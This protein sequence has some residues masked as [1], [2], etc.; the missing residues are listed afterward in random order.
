MPNDVERSRVLERL[1]LAEGSNLPREEE[2]LRRNFHLLQ[3]MDRLSLA[4]CSTEVPFPRVD[5]VVP[6]PGA[7]AVSVN[8]A[9]T[10]DFSIALDPWPFDEESVSFEIPYRSVPAKAYADVELFRSVYAAAPANVMLMTAHARQA[11]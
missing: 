6:K 7:R 11:R 9:R 1:G 8:L 4:F 10:G 5:H 3:L 2:N